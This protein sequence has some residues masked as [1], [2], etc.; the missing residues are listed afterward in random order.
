MRTVAR[1][2]VAHRAALGDAAE[3]DERVGG[4]LGLEVG[5]AVADHHDAR[6]RV[7]RALELGHHRGL[8]A[9]ARRRLAVVVPDEAARRVELERVGPDALAADA[10]PVGDGLD[11]KPE[12][13][14]DEAD[15]DAALVQLRDH[16]RDARRQPRRVRRE[17]GRDV[18]ARRPGI[19]RSQSLGYLRKRRFTSGI[20]TANRTNGGVTSHARPTR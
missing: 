16:L 4:R 6:V 11:H 14:G 5:P 20:N 8:A 3:P 9:A 10:E 1:R 7:R 13:A 18:R 19:G 12:A 17:A 2:A 15:R